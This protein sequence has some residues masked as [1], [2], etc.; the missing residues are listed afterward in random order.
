MAFLRNSSA[1]ARFISP[2]AATSAMI[3][4]V[5]LSTDQAQAADV[6]LRLHQFL[7][8]QS[9]VPAQ[10]LQPWADRIEKASDGRIKIEMYP[11]MTLGGRPT[12]LIDQA[13]D[14]VV[15]IIW[16]LPGYTPGRFPRTEVFELPFFG[17]N[18]EAT[19]RAYWTLFEE[20]MANTEFAD[21]KVLGT[22]V[23]GPGVIHNKG[24]PIATLADMNGKKLRG[25]TR[26]VNELLGKTG[27]VAVGMPVP[28]IPENLSKGV[29]DGAVIP[30][31][32]TTSLK[33]SELTDSHTEFGG[34]RM[35]YTATFVLAMN[36]ASYA[37]LP[38]DLKAVIDAESGLEF[39]TK[40]GA[41]Q[42]SFDAPARQIAVDAGNKMTLIDSDGL[43]EWNA[44]AEPVISA[45]IAEMATK[46]IDGQA[47]VDRARA[48]IDE[49][50]T[51]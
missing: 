47:L 41:I 39:S 33:I 1:K 16:T 29:I 6:T 42:Q 43:A 22:W 31:E 49:F 30:W 48:L 2:I 17:T 25:P 38:D 12:D 50:S 35:F 3:F 5:G 21:W 46:D 18:A 19:S 11:S 10:I 26:M 51:K 23:H 44:L 37:N 45:W 36:K 15:D 24:E 13:R 8:P 20:E 4:S 28:A 32:V 7:P 9:T 27:A 14:G 34:D 40:S